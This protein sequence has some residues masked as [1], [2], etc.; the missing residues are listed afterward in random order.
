MSCLEVISKLFTVFVCS[1]APENDNIKLMSRCLQGASSVQ[2]GHFLLILAVLD[3][4]RPLEGRCR[5]WVVL[6]SNKQVVYGVCLLC[7]T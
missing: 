7:S 2:N 3:L 4:F 1:V 5:P 6:G